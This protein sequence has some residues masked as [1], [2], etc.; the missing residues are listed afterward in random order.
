MAF[1][2]LLSAFTIGGQEWHQRIYESFKSKRK[3]NYYQELDDVA[4]EAYS[5]GQEDRRWIAENQVLNLDELLK[6]EPWNVLAAEETQR[7]P[8]G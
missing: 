2:F 5:V 3:P 6:E 1:N 7:V 4:K 8:S